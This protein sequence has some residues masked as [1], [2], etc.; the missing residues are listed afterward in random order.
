MIGV[1]NKIVQ[2]FAPELTAL[3][4]KYPVSYDNL[5]KVLNCPK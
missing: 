1:T 5:E 2:T 3:P 4:P